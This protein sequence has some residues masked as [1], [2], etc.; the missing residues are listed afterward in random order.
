VTG[1]CLMEASFGGYRSSS[2]QVSWG[3]RELPHLAMVSLLSKLPGLVAP[4]LALAVGGCFWVWV[5]KCH[6]AP[7]FPSPGGDALRCDKSLWL[8]ILFLYKSILLI[9]S[10]GPE[11]KRESSFTFTP[12]PKSISQF[13]LCHHV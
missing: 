13:S 1:V 10:S 3:G 8:Q 9:T 4:H 6:V 5:A 11:E 2:S 7:Q 12:S